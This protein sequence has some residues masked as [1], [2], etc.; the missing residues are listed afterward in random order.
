MGKRPGTCTYLLLV[1]SLYF[2]TT[3]LISKGKIKERIRKQGGS[4]LMKRKL[5]MLATAMMILA[6][7][8]PA[9][10]ELVDFK[11]RS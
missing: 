8:A 1:F 6:L 5:V 4:F 10:A 3:S 2:F 7:A 11:Q 9:W